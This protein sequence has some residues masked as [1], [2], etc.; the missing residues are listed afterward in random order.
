MNTSNRIE[1][2]PSAPVATS[3]AAAAPPLTLTPPPD[4]G[5]AAWSTIAGCWLALFVQFGLCNSFGVFQAYY[6]SNLLSDKSPSQI[7][8]IGTLQLFILFLGGIFVGRIL[9]SHGAHVLTVPGSFL[10]VLALMMTSLCKEYWQ[11]ILAQG[12]LFGIGCSLTFHPSV[13]LPPQWFSKKRAIAT[14]VAISGSGLGGVV[15]PIIIRELFASPKIGFQWGT[16]AVG[17]ISLGL[18]ALSNLLIHKR[19]PK[20]SPLPWFKVLHFCRD[21]KFSLTIASIAF[22]LFGFLVPFYYISTNAL[23]LGSSEALAFYT[24]SFMN[25]GSSVGR[26]LAGFIHF[27]KPITI[28]CT[29][30]L[31]CAIFLIAMWIPLNN[32]ASVIAFG[33]IYGIFSGI[34]LSAIPPCIASMSQLPE[35]GSKIGLTW[36]IAS[37]LA[38]VGAPIAGAIVEA[39]E[40][41]TGFR[42]AAL[43]SGIMMLVGSLLAFVVWVSTRQ[44]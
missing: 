36:G 25:A 14:A 12:I 5:F 30:S 3:A 10:I 8:W 34:W 23:A 31:L 35:I 33:I 32:I 24:L 13:S 6:E 39:H 9:D 43:F 22:T 44:K 20:R 16:R 40:G 4:G 1:K 38:L 41:L 37:L 29:T 2:P 17:F 21:W 11:L 15:W 19:A 7:A 27:L 42:L 18:L 26:L 28:I